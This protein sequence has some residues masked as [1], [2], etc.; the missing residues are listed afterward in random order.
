MNSPPRSGNASLLLRVRDDHFCTSFVH[1]PEDTLLRK[2][3]RQFR[4]QGRE[5]RVCDGKFVFSVAWQHELLQFRAPGDPAGEEYILLLPDAGAKMLK[6]RKA[7][8]PEIP[9]TVLRFR[10]MVDIAVSRKANGSACASE[11]SCPD[12]QHVGGGSCAICKHG[13][14]PMVTC[15]FCAQTFHDACLEHVRSLPT[16]ASI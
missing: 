10:H 15:S 8:R 12:D 14:E 4:L 1:W 11:P 2:G 6:V 13:K 5:I 3:Q 9:P 16:I 7:D